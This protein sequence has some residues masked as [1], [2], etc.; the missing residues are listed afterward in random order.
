MG[1][2]PVDV[3]ETGWTERGAEGVDRI[4]QTENTTLPS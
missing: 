2:Y 3:M 4:R 1:P